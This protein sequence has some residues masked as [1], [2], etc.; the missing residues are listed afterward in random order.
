MNYKCYIC[1]KKIFNEHIFLV[2]FKGRTRIMCRKC[3]VKYRK[4]KYKGG[5]QNGDA[6][7]V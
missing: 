6:D 2:G 1:G 7:R 3:G 5:I 4:D